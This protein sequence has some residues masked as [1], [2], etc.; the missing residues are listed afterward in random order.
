MLKNYIVASEI[1]ENPNEMFAKT[2]KLL[3]LDLGFQGLCLETLNSKKI[4]NMLLLTASSFKFH[5]LCGIFIVNS[6][7]EET[8]PVLGKA[9]Y[10]TYKLKHGLGKKNYLNDSKNIISRIENSL[11]LIS[12]S[13]LHKVWGTMDH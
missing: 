13:L 3:V 8:F 10:C 4:V 7:V 1:S 5:L 2:K 6:R 12:H 11:S 9:K